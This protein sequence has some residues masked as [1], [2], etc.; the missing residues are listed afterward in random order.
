VHNRLGILYLGEE[1]RA[2]AEREFRA[3]LEI[4]PTY[5]DAESNLGALYARQGSATKR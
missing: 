4:N 5:A 1:H 3:A 2:E